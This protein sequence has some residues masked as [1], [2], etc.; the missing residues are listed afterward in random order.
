M[1]W[2]MVGRTLPWLLL[3]GAGCEEEAPVQPP[4]TEPQPHCIRSDTD[5]DLRFD[6]DFPEPGAPGVDYD[7]DGWPVESDCDDQDPDVNLGAT[8][9]NNARDDD[10]D[11]D[12]EPLYGCGITS[13]GDAQS[14][15]QA[16][17]VR[18]EPARPVGALLLPLGLVG[19]LWN[20]RRGRA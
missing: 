13:Y 6:V 18:H 9:Y 1:A 8:E 7:C 5:T 12:P 10:C 3:V 20:R 11:G 19:A 4:L 14:E 17:R 2:K 15:A 16:S